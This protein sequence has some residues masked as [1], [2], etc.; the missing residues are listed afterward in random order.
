M[1][2]S[3]LLIKSASRAGSTSFFISF[4]NLKFNS[5]NAYLFFLFSGQSRRYGGEWHGYGDQVL[6]L[7][8]EDGRKWFAIITKRADARHEMVTEFGGFVS[9]RPK[10]TRRGDQSRAIQWVFE[11][12]F[13]YGV[14]PP[15]SL[16]KKL[17]NIFFCLYYSVIYSHI[18]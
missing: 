5:L 7:V 10:V 6:I 9:I 18:F 1:T 15:G 8:C 13:R 12:F 14:I 17:S 16:G 4:Q 11:Q 2:S 3:S